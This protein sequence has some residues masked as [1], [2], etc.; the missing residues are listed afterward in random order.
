M[1]GAT[2]GA[3]LRFTDGLLE[4][5]MDDGMQI[6]TAVGVTVGL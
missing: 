2:D 4:L 1:D 5:G 6:G 3:A